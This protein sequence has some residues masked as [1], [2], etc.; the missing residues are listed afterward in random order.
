[1]GVRRR[2]GKEWKKLAQPRS[3]RD[4]AQWKPSYKWGPLGPR[5]F[6]RPGEAGSGAP[7]A[8]GSGRG[9]ANTWGTVGTPALTPPAS[10]PLLKVGNRGLFPCYGCKRPKTEESRTPAPPFPG[11]R[12]PGP[13]PLPTPLAGHL[14]L[15]AWRRLG[16]G[17][18]WPGQA[19]RLGTAQLVLTLHAAQLGRSHAAQLAK[20]VGGTPSSLKEGWGAGTL[21]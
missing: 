4:C 1:M 21:I 10:K 3:W 12:S 15:V 17:G 7:L 2:E 6:P 11:P 5:H 16:G 18:A 20:Q 13:A 9:H 19:G 8:C 14:G